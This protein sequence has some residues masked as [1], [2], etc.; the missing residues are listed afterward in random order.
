VFV[1][2]KKENINKKME[3][4]DE[5]LIILKQRIRELI[6]ENS[7]MKE[8]ILFLDD[9]RNYAKE[10]VKDFNNKQTKNWNSMKQKLNILEQ[11]QFELIR[12]NYSLKQV[13]N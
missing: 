13:F 5:E 4:K 6:R 9:E 2:S 10:F 12:E 11:K 7:E 8:L 1:E 3:T